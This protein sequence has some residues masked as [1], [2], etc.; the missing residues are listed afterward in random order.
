MET[1]LTQAVEVTM[2]RPKRIY[3]SIIKVNNLFSFFSSRCFLKEIENMFSVFLS[4]ETL[5]KAMR[6]FFNILCETP[7][8]VSFYFYQKWYKKQ[9]FRKLTQTVIK[10]CTYCVVQYRIDNCKKVTR[11]IWCN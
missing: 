4:T 1:E 11:E 6:N 7:A 10:D 3:I 8:V 2:T 9:S 5:V